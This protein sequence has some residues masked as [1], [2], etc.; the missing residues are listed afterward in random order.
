MDKQKPKVAKTI[1]NNERTS[2][3]ITIPDVKQLYRY[4]VIN[5]TWYLYRNR[6][7]NQW[8]WFEHSQKFPHSYVH[9]IFDKEAQSHTMKK[10]SISS[11]WCWQNCWSVCR[12]MW[13]DPYLSFKSY[14]KFKSKWITDLNLK[15]N[16]LNLTELK[17]GNVFD[18]LVQKTIFWT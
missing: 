10:D 9:L 2:G 4:I 1:L 3:G 7:S 15:L 11:K 16:T 18:F 6:K 12:K 5:T 17:L 8:N 13:T 14:T